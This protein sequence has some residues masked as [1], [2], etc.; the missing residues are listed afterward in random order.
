MRRGYFLA[1]SG[2][3]LKR[4]GVMLERAAGYL[5]NA[6]RR[7][8]RDPNGLARRRGSPSPFTFSYHG[9]DLDSH[10]WLLVLLET[11][12]Q[13]RSHALSPT[14]SA[15]RA[16]KDPHTPFLDFLYPPPTQQFVAS[17][18]L[19]QSRR[20]VARR[21]KRSIPSL[22]RSYTSD[23][24]S[25]CQVFRGNEFEPNLL[26]GSHTEESRE[27][28]RIDLVT[29]LGEGEE[30]EYNRAWDLFAAAGHPPDMNSALLAYLCTSRDPVNWRR[31]NR[32]FDGIS[33]ENR[34][35]EDYFHL[36]K[37]RLFAGSL[38][39]A[40]SICLDALAKGIGVPCWTW[41]FAHFMDNEQY[42]LAINMW[43]VRPQDA[44]A[45]TLLSCVDTS[46]LVRQAAALAAYLQDHRDLFFGIEL[47]RFLLDHI[48]ASPEVIDTTPTEAILNILRKYNALGLVRANDYYTLIE[49]FGSSNV[50]SS[51]VRS[52]LVY[53]NFRWQMADEIPPAKILTLLLTRLASFEITSGIRY[54]LDEFSHFYTKPSIEAYKYALIA[55]SRA[56][57]VENIKSIFE[58]FVADHGKPL[59]RRLVNPLLYVHARLG[60][61]EGTRQQFR[62]IN[63]EFGLE[64]NTA[65]WN[66]LLTAHTRADDFSGAFSTFKQMLETGVQPDTHTFGTMMGLCANRGDIESVRSLLVVASQRRITITTPLLD[67]IVE[68]YCNNRR[69]DLAESMAEACLSLNVKGSLVRM[70]NVLLWNYA[71]RLDLESISRIRSR[72]DAAGVQPDGMTYA[73]LMLALALVGQPDS[74][75]RILRTLHRSR[76]VHATDFHYAIVLYGY[77]KTRNRDMVHIIYREIKER[78][79]RPG[80]GARLLVL[81]SQ[82]RRDLDHF[83]DTRSDINSVNARLQN[84]ERLLAE[85]IAD[86]EPSMLA[87][88][89]PTPGIGRQSLSRAFPDIYY[90]YL[91]KAYGAV[92]AS[93]KV[94]ELFDQYINGKQPRYPVDNPY[95]LAPLRLLS[96]LMLAHL[97]S[98]QYDKVEEFWKIAFPR[99]I[100][101]A[102]RPDLKEWLSSAP[103]GQPAS[104]P[105]LAVSGKKNSEL[106]LS[107][108]MPNPEEKVS[109]LPSYRF[110]LS[111][112]LSM[113]LRALAYQDKPWRL[114]QVMK[115]VEHAGFS[116]TT[117]NWSTYVQML[118]QSDRPS[119][120][121]EAFTVYEEKFMPNFPGWNNLRRGVGV[122]PPSAPDTVDLIENPRR[123][124]RGYLGKVGRRYWSK[125]QPDFMQPTYIS[126]V[127]LASALL[128][129]RERSIIDGGA[130]VRALYEAA[131]N[132]VQAVAGI[133]YLRDKFQGVILRHRQQRGVDPKSTK[134]YEPF[135]WT[136]G[137]LGVGGESRPRDTRRPK[138]QPDEQWLEPGESLRDIRPEQQASED[139]IGT[140]TTA[141]AQVELPESTLDHQD[142]YDI[143]AET[144][145][146]RR[147][148]AN[149]TE[150]YE[151]DNEEH[152]REEA[153]KAQIERVEEEEDE[154]NEAEAEMEGKEQEENQEEDE[155][156]ENE[157]EEEKDED[158]EEGEKEEEEEEDDDESEG[159]GK[160]PRRRRRRRR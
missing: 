52:I 81:R 63:D 111:W 32:L 72:M 19:R 160:G 18:V 39:E 103:V 146:E 106:P 79:N 150:D 153:R 95:E 125:I 54:L 78:F 110:M 3:A 12:D 117:F 126:M 138:Q 133:P 144:I 148:R 29:L 74:A 58:K 23:T 13:R 112:P 7:F 139:Q 73:A 104:H 145:L 48:I 41:M 90:E 26:A 17:C 64:P 130:E 2:L 30:G 156:G 155:E 15:R 128:S 134:P 100:K 127:Y 57:E 42:D 20:L 147:R 77:V 89:E 6:G 9:A 135:V 105:S 5:E 141:E 99:A 151:L 4:L 69:L 96:A 143:E 66:I 142:E 86:F 159:F 91:I 75:R 50:R 93:A 33:E 157:D 37:S 101:M 83:R 1:T 49:T 108:D 113:Y 97:R 62:R 115:E 114:S 21:R 118:A 149:A 120:Q 56:G 76:R 10:H 87:S 94:E 152:A 28:A 31:V 16:A 34:R 36:A 22:K 40:K 107:S 24:T 92:G 140:E 122:R 80:L 47:A 82:I 38:L 136:G 25:A 14:S 129:F 43:T 85:A 51:F 8:F 55:F 35:A 68:A 131:P 123:R 132:T 121:L 67:T 116:L 137:I 44:K 45:N 46:S 102:S 84:A 11:S 27:H 158:E 88:K 98:E 119:D 61:V 109:I 71:F 154:M 65:S 59:S 70:W 60:D 53:R 124:K